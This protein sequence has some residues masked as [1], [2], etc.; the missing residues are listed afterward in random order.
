MLKWHYY[1]DDSIDDDDYI[2]LA[3]IVTILQLCL[4]KKQ[5]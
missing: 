4:P 2:F 5:A 3:H 1:D